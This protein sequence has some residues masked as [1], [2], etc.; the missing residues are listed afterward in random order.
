MEYL[1]QKSGSKMLPVQIEQTPH[2]NDLNTNEA[3]NDTQGVPAVAQ[4]VKDLAL[5]QLWPRSKLQLGLN[6]WPGNFHVP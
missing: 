3:R 5:P 1:K 2:T 6:P 4:W